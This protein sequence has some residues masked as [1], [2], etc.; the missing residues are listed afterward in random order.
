LREPADTPNPTPHDAVGGADD[1]AEVLAFLLRPQSYGRQVV[2]IERIETHCSIVFL[3]GEHALKL[4]RPIVFSSTDY[5]T[6]TLR[7]RACRAEL[8]VNRAAAPDLYLGVRSINRGS[9]GVLRFNGPGPALDWVVVMR[10]FAQTDLFSSLADTGRLSPELMHQLG[11]EIARFHQQAPVA[12]DFGGRG[13]IGAAIADNGR[14]LRRVGAM[15]DGADLAQLQ[16]QTEATLVQIAELLE[17]RRRSGKVRRCHGDLR[18]PNICLFGGRPTLFDSIE[19]SDA[20][21]CIDVLYDLAFLVMDLLAGGY[22]E[23]ANTLFN[24]Y[25]D[26]THETDGLAALPLFLAVRAAT[27]SYALVGSALRHP[28]KA[29]QQ[30]ASARAHLAASRAYLQPVPPCLLAMAEAGPDLALAV[31]MLL[32]PQPGARI[33]HLRDELPATHLWSTVERVLAAGHSVLVAGRFHQLSARQT[34]TEIAKAS[35]VPFVG[36]VRGVG[37]DKVLPAGWHHLGDANTSDET[38]SV[39][40]SLLAVLAPCD[41]SHDNDPLV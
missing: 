12:T 34:A 38:M 5:S 19:F 30:L 18:L 2:T 8:A 10:R 4:K 33:L 20:L 32:P 6:V 24:A 28:E 17:R 29:E 13:G 16:A 35:R 15:L 14:E 36:L 39:V 1:Q 9:D 3:V 23:L 25:L 22:G 26:A 40:K 27:R 7:E 11:L 41:G 21:G 31:A 37:G